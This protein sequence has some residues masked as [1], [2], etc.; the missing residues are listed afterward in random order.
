MPI[1][2]KRCLRVLNNTGWV[3][4]LIETSRG[5]GDS[6]DNLQNL[7]EPSVRSVPPTLLATL[8]LAARF[9]PNFSVPL[10]F[11]NR[12]NGNNSCYEYAEEHTFSALE[13]RPG[14]ALLRTLLHS[15]CPH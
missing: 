14:L 8:I 9:I 4:R 13:H 15:P 7:V 11:L 12:K 1:L 2:S 3:H 5:I 10:S 6:F